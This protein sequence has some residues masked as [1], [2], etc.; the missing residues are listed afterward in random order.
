MF[1]LLFGFFVPLVMLL[2]FAQLAYTLAVVLGPVLLVLFGCWVV[3]RLV[4]GRG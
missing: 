3:Y 2:V 1:F 4:R